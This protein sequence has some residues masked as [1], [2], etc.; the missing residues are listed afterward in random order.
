M[1]SSR[2]IGAAS[3]STFNN[4]VV[5]VCGGAGFIGS[6]FIHYILGKYPRV[7]IVNL[8]ALT[9]SGNLE[10]LKSIS[11]DKRYSFVRGDI[12]DKKKVNFIFKKHKP[13][14]VINFAAETHVD[15]S[16]HVGALEF[17]QTNVVG[18][19]N[20]LEA[21]RGTPSVAK[22]VQVSTDEV[23]GSLPLDSKKLFTE[24]TSFAPNVPYAAT[25]AGGDMLCRA[26]HN[27]W[28]VPVVV[29]HCS[30]NYGPRQYPEKLI[31]FFVLRMLEGKSLPLYGDGK[32]VRD[33]IYVLDH[34]SALELCLLN[35]V[36]GDTYNIGADN[37]MNNHDIAT[38]IATHFGKDSSAIEYVG[39]R[40]G[41]DRRYAI[42]ASHIR[43]VLGWK[44]EHSFETAFRETLEWYM[45]N[46]AW[47]DKV[48]KKTGI[49]N[50]HIDLWRKHGVRK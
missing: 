18:V 35:G 7:R 34:C 44:P 37:E 41:H 28:G 43:K 20:I 10:N 21:I 9:Y 48:R 24:L 12:A 16:I 3:R 33:W 8:D 32:H 5:L 47:V 40:P 30:N 6:N 22:F 31:P 42:D 50:P 11:K 1:V 14:Y 27:T 23:Y 45:E 19:F 46:M 39:D 13:D 26:Y 36:A 17:I 4:K 38:R 25:K 49:F 2:V 15:R 29:T